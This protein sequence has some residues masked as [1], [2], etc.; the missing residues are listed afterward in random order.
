MGWPAVVYSEEV[1]REGFGIFP[2]CKAC[3][4]RAISGSP[5]CLRDRSVFA[6]AAAIAGPWYPGSQERPSPDLAPG[7]PRSTT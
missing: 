4:R 3:A 1:M 2:Q 5:R 7:H 6:M